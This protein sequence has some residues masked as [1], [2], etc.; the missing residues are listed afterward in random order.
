MYSDERI[1]TGGESTVNTSCKFGRGYSLKLYRF[2][3]KFGMKFTM[4]NSLIF[5]DVCD[6]V[7][8]EVFSFIKGR[9]KR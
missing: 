3:W 8:L 2:Y 7:L 6:I 4:N 1:E 5:I 9:C